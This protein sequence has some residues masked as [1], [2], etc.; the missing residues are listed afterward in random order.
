MANKMDDIINFQTQKNLDITNLDYIEQEYKKFQSTD[1]S[2][3]SEWKNFFQGLEF[4]KVLFNS[5]GGNLDLKSLNFFKLI[6]FYRNYGHLKAELTPI[7][8]FNKTLRNEKQIDLFN[9]SNFQLTKEDLDQ[10]LLQTLKDPLLPK[11]KAKDIIAHLENSY[12][13]NISVQTSSCKPEVREWF[14]NQ[15]ENNPFTLNSEYKKQILSNLIK[16]ENLE[17]FIHQ[18][19]LGAKRFSI[20][21]VD[22]LI[23]MLDLGVKFSLAQGCEEWVIGMAHR[24][25]L[26]VLSTFMQKD[27]EE[28]L[29]LFINSDTESHNYTGDVKY[30]IGHSSNIET[31]QGSFHCSLSFNPSHLEAINPVVCGQARAKQRFRKDTLKRKSVIPILIHGDAAFV[32]QGVSS[33]TLQ[34]SFPKGYTVGGS[35]HIILNNQIG[36]TTNP[37]DARSTRYS[38]DLGHSIKAPIILVNADNAEA[39]VKAMKMAVDFRQT[40]G[41]DIIIEVTGYRRFG[42]NEAD[43]P[44]FTQPEL[45]KLISKHPTVKTIYGKQIQNIVSEEELKKEEQKIAN[46]LQETLDKIKSPNYKYV[47]NKEKPN[48]LWEKYISGTEEDILKP[49]HTAISKDTAIQLIKYLSKEPENFNLNSKIKRLLDKREGNLNNNIIDWPTAELLAYASLRQEGISVRLSGQDVKRGTFSHRHAVFTDQ[50]NNKEYNPLREINLNNGEFCVYNSPL[51]EFAVLAYEYGNSVVDPSFLSIW[52]AQFGDFANGAQ[53][54]IDQFLSS[55]EQKWNRYSGL[56]LLL[57]HG[58]EGQGPEHSSA[59]LE[60]FLQLCAQGN[61]QVC[62]LTTPANLFHALRRQMKTN[63]KKPLVIMSPKSLLRH[64]KNIS[65]IDDFCSSGFKEILEEPN[66]VDPKKVESVILC[67]GKVFFELEELKLQ[68]PKKNQNLCSIIRIEQL[69]PLN[70][71][72]LTSYINAYPKLKKIIWVQ[73]EPKNMGAYSYINIAL[74]NLLNTLGLNHIAFEY[75]G[76]PAMASTAEGS[77]SM[78][79]KEQKR[80]LLDALKKAFVI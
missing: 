41:E 76:R 14:Y 28:T 12:C 56:V 51:S 73:E 39:C 20:E 77:S 72:Q 43:E 63:F 40:F 42:H 50:I 15:M 60:R 47:P 53:V 59:R 62:N 29:N 71:T 64:H 26:N 2:L 8:L 36:F 52:E 11:G 61:M 35:I 18:R 58:H 48:H 75:A 19:F 33:E 6:Q 46:H 7:S 21:G 79:L 44:R 55:G 57:P 3:S 31:T 49:C 9:I 66:L 67:S 80:L 22:V 38:S 74:Q 37:E 68:A 24:G 27:V 16:A 69:Y 54:I 78:H 34:L 10:S 45:Y 1:P 23:P 5:K 13:K 4:S 32:G 17:K 30:H 25:R 70:I 65:T